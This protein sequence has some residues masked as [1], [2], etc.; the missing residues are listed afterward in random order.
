MG[1]SRLTS[2]LFITALLVF[3]GSESQAVIYKYVNDKGIPAF[4]DDMQKVPEQFRA[5]AVIVSGGNEFDAYT[6]QEKAKLA[7]EMRTRQ[8]QLAAASVKIEEPLSKR[9]IRS[10]IAVGIFIALLLV[11]SHIDALKEQARLLFRIRTVL[12]VLLLVFLGVTHARDVLGLFTKVGDALPNP[13][14]SIQE[15]SAERGKKAADAYKA[16]GKA[17]EQQA[18]SEE[19]PLRDTEKKVDDAER[20]K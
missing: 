8:E 16:L 20:G 14:A 1:K 7:A 6:E 4:A 18:Q 5:Q 2:I 3:I 19:S 10:G 12:V 11:A 17:L 15:K 13:M 9:L